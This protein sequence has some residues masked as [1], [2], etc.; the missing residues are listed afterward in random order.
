MPLQVYELVRL[1]SSPGPYLVT[2]SLSTPVVDLL[3]AVYHHHSNLSLLPPPTPPIP[4]PTLA[5]FSLDTKPCLHDWARPSP[6][7]SHLRKLA[8]ERSRVLSLLVESP[9]LP[10]T[11]YLPAVRDRRGSTGFAD[12]ACV[13]PLSTPPDL[14]SRAPDG[15]RC[16][17]L[18]GHATSFRCSFKM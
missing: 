4:A 16:Q 10:T 11:T 8:D 7:Q 9:S 14:R 2:P 5:R 18:L 1:F 15:F 12:L 3:M 6:E 17:P 13:G